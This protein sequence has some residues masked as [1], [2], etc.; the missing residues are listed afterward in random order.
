MNIS[1]PKDKIQ[2]YRNSSATCTQYFKAAKKYCIWKINNQNTNLRKNWKAMSWLKLIPAC[3]RSERNE[4][5]ML[6]CSSAEKSPATE[7]EDTYSLTWTRK[8]G[9]VASCS[10]RRNTIF[11]PCEDV[12]SVITTHVYTLKWVNHLTDNVTFS[13]LFAGEWTERLGKYAKVTIPKMHCIISIR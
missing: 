3:V 7:H 12:I 11:L 8:A 9:S 5:P 10:W 1:M 4:L 13:Y 6:I 2:K